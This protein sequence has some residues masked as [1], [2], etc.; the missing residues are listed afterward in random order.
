MERRGKRHHRV[1]T[2]IILAAE[3]TC[4]GQGR[5]RDEPLK[6]CPA[7]QLLREGRHEFRRGRFLHETHERLERAEIQRVW[8]L[9]TE[10]GSE[11]Q[12]A[13][14]SVTDAGNQHAASDIRE[15]FTSSLGSFHGTSEVEGDRAIIDR[16]ACCDLRSRLCFRDFLTFSSSDQIRH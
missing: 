5:R 15:K 9:R 10:G 13:R 7:L 11:S 4:I 2:H 16:Y 6:I 12:F 14:H 3:G 1:K 8:R